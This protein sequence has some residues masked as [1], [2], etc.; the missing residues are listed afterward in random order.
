VLYSETKEEAEEEPRP[1]LPPLEKNEPLD[2]KGLTTDQRFTKPPPRYTEASLIKELEQ[3]GIGRP[4]TYAPII[5]TIVD[6]EYVIKEK[7]QL[8][9]TE[10]GKLVNGFLVKYFPEIVN[11]AF[12]AEM[13]DK[14]DRVAAGQTDWT[15][16]VAD[17]YAP[18]AG[19]LSTV[20]EKA[21]RLRPPDIQTE[22]KCPKCAELLVVKT[23][24]FG[25][26]LCHP[27][28]PQLNAKECKYTSSYQVKTGVAC[29]ECGEGEMVEKWNTK[30]KHVFYGCSRYPECKMATNFKPVP[31]PC[32]KC[33][34]L[35]TEYRIKWAR[36]TK[37]GH[38]KK[39]EE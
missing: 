30:K 21:E 17:F 3:Q 16:V 38:R 36:C 37:C 14:L 18:L 7:M 5:S 31:G 35:M 27:E 8:V 4:S 26:F 11:V 1:A 23:G 34:G 2:F 15:K 33:G 39:L 32:P 24:R 29:P 9:P 13:E 6:R 10:L 25:K 12:T 19:K 28:Y 22:E 20:E